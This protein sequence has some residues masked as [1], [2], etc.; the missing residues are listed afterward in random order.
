MKLVNL[1]RFLFEVTENF[2]RLSRITLGFN[3]LNHN[4]E[5]RYRIM[6][7]CLKTRKLQ[8]LKTPFI[9]VSQ[10]LAIY[11]VGT[12]C[13]LTSGSGTLGILKL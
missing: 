9:Q 10:F 3:V 11:N 5:E 1:L 8:S 7:T 4:F 13:I 12:Y 2:W 6:Q